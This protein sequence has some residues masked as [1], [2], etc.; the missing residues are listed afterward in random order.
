M[1]R[2][3]ADR[4]RITCDQSAQVQEPNSIVPVATASPSPS[5][6]TNRS[7]QWLGYRLFVPAS[8][9]TRAAATSLWAVRLIEHVILYRSTASTSTFMSF[10]VRQTLPNCR[11][12]DIHTLGAS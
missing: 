10:S 12:S 2:L 1:L 11:A 5:S 8:S 9:R 7:A 4:Y 3:E 6:S